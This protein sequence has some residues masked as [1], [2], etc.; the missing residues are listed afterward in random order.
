M[1]F[2]YRDRRDGDRQKT[3]HLPATEFIGRFLK[4][5]LPD[6]FMRIRHIS[7]G[8]KGFS[9]PASRYHTRSG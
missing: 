9:H 1:S 5:I 8:P 2:L 6:G 7:G 3:A 4:H